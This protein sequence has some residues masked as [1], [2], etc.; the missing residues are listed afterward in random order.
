MADSLGF[1]GGLTC[2]LQCTDLDASIAWYTDKLG[3][4]HLY[5]VNEIGWAE[6]S[7]CVDRVNLGLSLVEAPDVQGGATPTFGVLSVDTAR[8][9][10]EAGGVRFDGDTLEFPGMVRLATFFD[11]DGN[12]LMLY[13]DLSGG[14]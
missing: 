6:M 8:N 13:Q 5:T 12:K 7:T 1:D 9:K 3:F 11:P 2:S 4:N 14:S 10:L